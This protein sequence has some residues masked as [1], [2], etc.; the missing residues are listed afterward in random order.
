VADRVAIS[1]GAGAQFLTTDKSL[2][3]QQFPAAVFAN[4]GVRPRLLL[5]L[6]FSF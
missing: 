3:A 1:F 6:G 2:P 5:A 4:R